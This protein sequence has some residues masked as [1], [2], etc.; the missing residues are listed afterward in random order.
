MAAE[1]YKVD[2]SL[3]TACEHELAELQC[4]KEEE[5]EGGQHAAVHLSTVLLCL[6]AGMRE[7]K[8]KV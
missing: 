7:Q 5:E 3:T 8:V 6:E 1:D 2:V 4:S